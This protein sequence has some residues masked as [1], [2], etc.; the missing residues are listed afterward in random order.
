M[1][2]IEIKGL[3]KVYDS[4]S[5]GPV[6]LT[7]PQGCIMGLIGENGAG[8]ST[9]IKA[10][11]G[12]ISSEGSIRLLGKDIRSEAAS[13]KQDIG[14]VPDEI[15]LPEMLNVK[16]VEK[17]MKD[18]FTNWDSAQFA[19]YI[20]RFDLPEKKAFKTFSKGMK[21][22][23]GIAIALS[24]HAKLLILDEPTSGLDPLV[25][26]EIVGILNDFTRDENH[27]ILISS[28]IVSDLEKIC[29]YIAFLHKGRLMLCEEKDRL[30]EQYGILHTTKDVLEGLA[31]DAVIG[32]RISE[33]GA[34]AI[35]RRDRVPASFDTQ[36][37][38]IEELF[39]IMAKEA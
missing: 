35:V 32:K 21:M 17:I 16:Q 11:L 28:H 38:T 15:G 31:E 13:V 18:T 22:K 25:R 2:A 8:K 26:D 33:Y 7:L 10:M 3:K 37:V 20:K 6:D 29:D 39:V 30:L 19:D 1:N 34:E 4:Y 23:L 27:S 5:L 9:S 14:V 12:M 36:P 24:H